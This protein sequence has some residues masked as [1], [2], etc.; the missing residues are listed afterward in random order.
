MTELNLD[1]F[2]KPENQ[3]QV[4]KDAQS[5]DSNR[6]Y[7]SDPTILNPK[8]KDGRTNIIEGFFLPNP[9]PWIDRYGV[10]RY[11]HLVTIWEHWYQEG[12]ENIKVICPNRMENELYGQWGKCPVCD[13]VKE[14]Y[15]Y[16][17]NSKDP[18]VN[19]ENSKRKAKGRTF[20][21][22]FVVD[23]A[24][25]PEHNGKVFKLEVPAVVLK[26]L[27]L[28]LDGEKDIDSGKYT[29]NPENIFAFPNVRKMRIIVEKSKVDATWRNFD[30]SEFG[31]KEP[32]LGGDMDKIKLTLLKCH[33]LYDNFIAPAIEIMPSFDAITQLMKT[34][35]GNDVLT[36]LADSNYEK[37]VSDIPSH[38]QEKEEE[39]INTKTEQKIVNNDEEE[40]TEISDIP[41]FDPSEY[42]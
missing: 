14:K 18:E 6:N 39:I 25:F 4:L 17:K 19:K 36:N 8:L 23:D 35:Y 9:Y 20:I 37:D 27:R 1:L 32:F 3:E 12:T 42:K 41:V 7:D 22:F 5:K 26:K 11:S 38:T 10:S 40:S 2:L 15:P 31:D 13:Y 16:V 29:I 34:I 33:N 28:K 24:L 30:K 21:N